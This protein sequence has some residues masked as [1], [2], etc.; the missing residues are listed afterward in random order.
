MLTLY[1]LNHEIIAWEFNFFWKWVF[2][3]PS[4][5]IITI[6]MLLL[7]RRQMRP[8]PGAQHEW[9]DNRRVAI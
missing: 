5:E 3:E 7:A 4:N 8:S 1:S 2:S 9:T 6:H